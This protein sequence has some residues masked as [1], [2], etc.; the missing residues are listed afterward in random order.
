MNNIRFSSFVT[1][2]EAFLSSGN[3]SAYQ[4]VSENMSHALPIMSDSVWGG[5][6][7]NSVPEPL[8]PGC[9]QVRSNQLFCIL[10]RHFLFILLFIL[11]S[12]LLVSGPET[13]PVEI[14]PHT[15]RITPL[16]RMGRLTDRVLHAGVHCSVTIRSWVPNP[17]L[18]HCDVMMCSVALSVWSERPL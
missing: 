5:V 16:R 13:V 1:T 7:S 6:S 18:V 17:F 10:F 8:D 9:L 11:S 3:I 14:V 2:R 4:S 15:L 12:S